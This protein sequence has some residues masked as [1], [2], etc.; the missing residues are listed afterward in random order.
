MAIG[1]VL[2]VGAQQLNRVPGV[3]AATLAPSLSV[4]VWILPAYVLTLR[5]KRDPFVVHG[6]LARAQGLKV[7]VGVSVVI[8]G[9]YF[10]V[11]LIRFGAP[12]NAFPWSD[13]VVLFGS[14]VVLVAL[15]EEYF[16]RGV[17]QPALDRVEGPQR[18]LLGAP[19]GRGAIAAAAL[20]ALCHFV[21]V[22]SAYLVAPSVYTLLIFF[23][24]L[25][26]AWLRARTGSILPGIVA[27][28][29]ANAAELGAFSAWGV[30][31]G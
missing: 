26:F 23:P 13:A 12:P 3:F 24:A 2:F 8:L 21:R 5:R 11:F 30:G 4:L 25:W 29:L 15:P 28:A 18:K 31:G 14:H 16:F 1:L 9:A 10:A 27:H 17:L 6:L 20:F 7:A 22:P 19:F